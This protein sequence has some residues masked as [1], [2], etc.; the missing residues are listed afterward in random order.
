MKLLFALGFV[1][2]INVCLAEYLPRDYWYVVSDEA[3]D[4]IPSNVC[5]VTGVVTEAWSE[6]K[7]ENGIISNLDRSSNTKSNAQGEFKLTLSIKDTAIFF[8]HPKYAEIVCWDYNFQGGHHVVM[9]FVTSDKLPDGVEIIEEKPVIYAYSDED[10]TASLQLSNSSSLTFTYPKY[11]D[12]WDVTISK[13]QLSVD[14]QNYPY[15]FWEGA[16]DNLSFQR[17]EAGLFG[18]Q[19]DTDTSI[20]FLENVLSELNF[21]PTEKADFITYWAPR[22]EQ[23]DYADIQFLI[24]ENY[25][26]V[27]GDLR[28]DPKPE[29]ERRV[30]MI[31]QG[32]DKYKANPIILAPELKSFNREGFYLLEWGGA[33]LPKKSSL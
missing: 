13:N 3:L 15:L 6:G 28:V 1:F 30:F 25:D 32:S 4:S 26:S 17:S 5:V 29:N 10:L 9:N 11:D 12:G 18:F 19:I 2:S 20:Q 21:N 8:F 22:I 23:T 33:E 16:H 14:G 31:F 27:I 24:D 7:V